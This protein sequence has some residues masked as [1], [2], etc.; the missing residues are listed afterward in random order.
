MY[1]KLFSLVM[2]I[3][4]VL[5]FNG[6]ALASEPRIANQQEA[7]EAAR[8]LLPDIVKDYQLVQITRRMITGV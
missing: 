2:G 4:L 5:M 6:T 1:K 3:L 7:I 8:K